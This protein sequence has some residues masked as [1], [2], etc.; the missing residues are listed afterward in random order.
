MAA[1]QLITD[2]KAEQS[3]DQEV[4]KALGRFHQH[5]KTIDELFG[6]LSHDEDLLRAEYVNE[7]LDRA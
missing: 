1:E 3:A 5:R 4:I 7:L 6:F 2:S